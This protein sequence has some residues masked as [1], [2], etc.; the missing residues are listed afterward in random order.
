MAKSKNDCAFSLRFSSDD[1]SL[2]YR[3]YDFIKCHRCGYL[4]IAYF[5]LLKI[6]N[7]LTE[8]SFITSKIKGF[9]L[10]HPQQFQS[11]AG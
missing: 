5:L 1:L 11:Q 2:F 6:K 4:N 7:S 3:K 10:I 9:S 8:S